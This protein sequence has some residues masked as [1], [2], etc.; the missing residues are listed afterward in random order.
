MHFVSN[1]DSFVWNQP[2][3]NTTVIVIFSA[4]RWLQQALFANALSL[5]LSVFPVNFKRIYEGNNIIFMYLL[6]PNVIIEA[7]RMFCWEIVKYYLWF[8]TYD[9]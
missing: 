5:S 4:Y 6:M 1:K 7:D 9:I 3:I 8:D 2:I